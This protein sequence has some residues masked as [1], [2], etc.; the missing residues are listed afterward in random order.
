MYVSSI[1][2]FAVDAVSDH[3]KGNMCPHYG[4]AAMNLV[5]LVRRKW[6]A[7]VPY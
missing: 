4:V 6:L 3:T 1:V 2:L 7:I 5:F